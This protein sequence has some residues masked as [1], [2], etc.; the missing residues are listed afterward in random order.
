MKNWTPKIKWVVV[1]SIFSLSLFVT[2]LVLH[3]STKSPTGTERVY[4]NKE[5][6]AAVNSIIAVTP[7]PT[8]IIDVTGPD[9]LKSTKEV[10]DSAQYR[11]DVQGKVIT[12]LQDVLDCKDD[13]KIDV[14]V[15]SY[16]VKQLQ[17]VIS[18]HSFDVHSYFWLSG[19]WVLM[20]VLFWSLFGLIA[21]LMYSVTMAE[22]FEVEWVPEH[23]GKLFYTPL[24]TIVIYLSLNALINSGSVSFDEVGKNTI[25]LAF[26]LGFFTKRTIELLKKVR[27]ILL[28]VNDQKTT[29]ETD[30][31]TEDPPV[32]SDE[33]ALAKEAISQNEAELKAKYPMIDTLE[34][35]VTLSNVIGVIA[36]VTSAAPEDFPT[37]LSV[38]AN[39]ET[40]SVELE[41]V[42][43]EDGDSQAGLGYRL[44]NQSAPTMI[45]SL[46]A[47]LVS[48]ETTRSRILLTCSHVALGGSGKNEGGKFSGNENIFVLERNRR[49]NIGKL[50]YARLD[51]G[52]DVALAQV[53][54]NLNGV[55]NEIPSGGKLGKVKPLSE[56]K[57]N[58]KVAFYSSRIS[59]KIEGSIKRISSQQEVSLRYTDGIKKFKGLIV[60]G[61]RQTGKKGAISEK[62]DSGSVIFTED[63]RPFAMIIGGDNSYTY[64]IPIEPILKET[65]TEIY[66]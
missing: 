33:E 55:D 3:A 40:T 32:S 38:T 5:Q 62:G 10:I 17:A 36:H 26:I 20:E 12:Y 58:D 49:K 14:F 46:G 37:S 15:R 19:G 57:M 16:D 42:L 9:S 18:T 63:Y 31:E 51:E 53:D 54:R 28:P 6:L 11:A 29:S 59:K 13:S 64:A 21:N 25:V 45:G 8:K 24:T 41:A 4:L 65:K 61:H 34:P 35:G 52:V 47:V 30:E 44:R 66:I 2:Y 43:I 1:A 56:M 22:K 23:I 27:D 39:G 60:L 48:S 50:I 7:T